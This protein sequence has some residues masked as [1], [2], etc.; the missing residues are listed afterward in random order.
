MLHMPSP[1]LLRP[2]GPKTYADFEA[3]ITGQASGGSLAWDATLL[4][5]GSFIVTADNATTLGGM[6]GSTWNARFQGNNTNVNRAIQHGLPSESV[7]S[8]QRTAGRKLLITISSSAASSGYSA[9]F[10]NGYGSSSSS[11]T[12]GGR[13][14]TQLL[15]WDGSSARMMQPNN[16]IGPT[17]YEDW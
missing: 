13:A 1:M 15:Y 17:L 9:L 7:F 4:V 2:I 12:F 6:V 16:G 5:S 10:R 14:M 3:Y 11:A 8:D